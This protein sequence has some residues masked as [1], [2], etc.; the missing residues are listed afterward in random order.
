MDGGTQLQYTISAPFF[1]GIWAEAPPHR[2]SRAAALPWP[3]LDAFG[4]GPEGLSWEAARDTSTQG[5]DDL[6]LLANGA[7]GNPTRPQCLSPAAPPGILGAL[8]G[9]PL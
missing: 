4:D 7:S 5:S 2:S 9:F 8:Q 1:T 6:G 3:R